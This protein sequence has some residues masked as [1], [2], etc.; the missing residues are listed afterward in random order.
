MGSISSVKLS[1]AMQIHPLLLHG[2]CWHIP[3]KVKDKLL[4]TTQI[5]AQCLEGPLWIWEAIYS[6]FVCITLEHLPAS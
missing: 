5:E 3:P 6:F 2:A 1:S 4:H